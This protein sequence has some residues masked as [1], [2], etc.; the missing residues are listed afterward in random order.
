[1]L[2]GLLSVG[3]MELRS[4]FGLM[5]PVWFWQIV[6]QFHKGVSVSALVHVFSITPLNVEH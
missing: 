6:H 4:Y 3:V 5:F 2:V 1:M